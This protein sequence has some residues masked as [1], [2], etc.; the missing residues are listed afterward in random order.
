MSTPKIIT[1][2]HQAGIS[3]SIVDKKLRFTPQKRLTAELVEH[4]KENKTEIANYLKEDQE[5][6]VIKVHSEVLGREV[7]FASNQRIKDKVESEG[8]ATYLPHELEHL[9]KIKPNP[10]ELNKINLIKEIFPG[11]KIV[12]N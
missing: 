4:I 1:E 11:S 7:Y 3:F 5:N 10:E 8:L 6:F 2:L 12:W 9:V